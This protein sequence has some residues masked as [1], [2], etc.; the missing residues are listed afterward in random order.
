MR[1]IDFRML[2]KISVVWVIIMVE[3]RVMDVMVWFVVLYLLLR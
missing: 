3:V 1:F 2:K